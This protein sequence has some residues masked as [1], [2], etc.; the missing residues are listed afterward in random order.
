MLGVFD[1]SDGFVT[2]VGSITRNGRLAAF[3][4]AVKYKMNGSPEGA[5][6]YVE[7]RPTG[8]VKLKSASMQSLSIVANTGVF[9]GKAK[10]NGV[11]NH[12]FRATV[13]DNS[14][15][16]RTDR[17]GLQVTAPG[18]AVIPDLTFDPITLN[19]GNILVSDGSGH[20]SASTALK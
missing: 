7:H 17:F 10:V 4:F 1:P 13:V 15:L 11:G 19:S 18:G 8:L 5:L 6:L 12:T 16:G 14:L 20:H 9:I 3:A 2:G